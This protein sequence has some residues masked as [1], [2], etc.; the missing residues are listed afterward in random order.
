MAPR[1]GNKGKQDEWER[2]RK[3]DS[4]MAILAQEVLDDPILWTHIKPEARDAM[5]RR[6][7]ELIE[8]ELARRPSYRPKVSTGQLVALLAEATKS[9][10]RAIALAAKMTK[11]KPATV[12]RRYREY[13]AQQRGGK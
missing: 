4:W 9:D 11:R 8:R 13:K 3:D 2:R 12:A 10:Q 7:L 6:F 5:L 1:K